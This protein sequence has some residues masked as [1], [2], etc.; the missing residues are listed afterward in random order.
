GEEQLGKSQEG[1]SKEDSAE[2]EASEIEQPQMAA[3]GSQAELEIIRRE[4][5]RIQEELRQRLALN[6]SILLRITT[7]RE[8]FQR[9]REEA[10]RT[11]KVEQAEQETEGFAK[12]IAILESV[13]PKTALEHL[14][15]LG[16]P[17]EAAT[18]LLAMNTRKAK[19]IVEAAK[20]PQ[21]MEQMR[22]VV[23]QL[24]S[25]SPERSKEIVPEP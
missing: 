8:S 5:A 14:L 23:R 3:A 15:G 10:A 7:E 22:L 17:D 19:K 16:D 25:V 24:R 20:S 9:E 1:V 4:A 6:N 12:Q 13:K 11:A 18:V 21:E 2:P